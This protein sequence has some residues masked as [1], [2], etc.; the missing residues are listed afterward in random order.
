VK[1]RRK[2]FCLSSVFCH[3]SS[4]FYF[5]ALVL[6]VCTCPALGTIYFNDGGIHNIDYAIKDNVY[7]DYESPEMYTTVNFLDG[8]HIG[9]PRGLR[10]Y[11]NSRINVR[12]GSI[13]RF[14]SYDSS[15]VNIYGGSI[16]K[17]VSYDLTQIDISGG[18]INKLISLDS[19]KVDISDVLIDEYIFSYNSSQVD[20]SGGSIESRLF[21][22]DSS[23][24]NI[25]GGSISLLGSHGTSQV[26]ISGGSIGWL[27]SLD[28]SQVDIS[29]GSIVGYL[30]LSNQSLIQ[31]FGSGFAVDGLPFGYGELTSLYGGSPLD[32]PYR[33]LTG[34][35]LNGGFI[36]S[37]FRIGSVARIVLI[38]EPATLLLL[39]L[40]GLFLRRKR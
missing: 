31:I 15:Q 7:V 28:F 33:H 14:Y 36:D 16:D 3:P 22:Y 5:T 32:E 8:G 38:P 20:I 21:S 37:D 6:F 1:N 13:W 4:I 26:D 10:G 18:S 12:D 23:Q 34:T 19:S 35:L 11:E 24:I 39:G 27:Y 25:S 30:Q 17:L 40:G 2:I 29:G 9:F